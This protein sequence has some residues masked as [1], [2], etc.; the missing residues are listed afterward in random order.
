[1]LTLTGHLVLSELMSNKGRIDTVLETD[2]FIVIFEFKMDSS[3]EAA[4]NQ[5][6]EKN[7]AER[8]KLNNKEILFAGV[9]F[10]SGKRSVVDWKIE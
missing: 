2:D 10:D 1:M 3:A 6:H 8:Y 4:L 7:Y 9:N 5:I